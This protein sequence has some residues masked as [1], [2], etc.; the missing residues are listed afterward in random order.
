M[1]RV[2]QPHRLMKAAH[3]FGAEGLTQQAAELAAKAQAVQQQAKGAAELVERSRAGDQNAMGTIA[4]LRD[5]AIKGGLRAK[6]SCI[7]IEE[8]CKA[9]PPR[10]H[11]PS[12]VA[13]MAAQAQQVPID[14][15]V[16][17]A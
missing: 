6:V 17:H 12:A 13:A 14:A 3:L 5:V 16:A 10:E 1:T 4:D 15:A 2:H 11:P 8:Y 9:N 7:L